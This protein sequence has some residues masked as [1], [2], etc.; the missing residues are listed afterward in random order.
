MSILQL[1]R[2]EDT[3]R[4]SSESKKPT[5]TPKSAAMLAS[6]RLGDEEKEKE[7]EEMEQEGQQEQNA[8]INNSNSP[9]V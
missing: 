6:V 1:S 3:K 2:P 9:S 8:I 5:D 4:D 7:Q